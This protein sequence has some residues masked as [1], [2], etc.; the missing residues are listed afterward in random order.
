LPSIFN[1][2]L[3]D[4]FDLNVK[5]YGKYSK[6]NAKVNPSVIQEYGIA[7]FR[8][9]HANINNNIPILDKNIFK[10]S[11]MPLKFNF[12]QMTELWDGNV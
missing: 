9:S 12:N 10:I 1:E 5:P 6:Y 2:K 3:Y 7:A 11:Q 4:F 8:Y